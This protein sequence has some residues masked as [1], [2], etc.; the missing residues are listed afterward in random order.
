MKPEFKPYEQRKD[1]LSV[2]NGCILWGSRVVVPPPGRAPVIKMLHEGHPGVS[3]MK[4]LARSV[5]WWPGL[6]LELEKQVKQ[7]AECQ[8][9]QKSP[10]NAVLHPWE[11]PSKPWSRVHA[12]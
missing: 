12:Y 2:Q 4:A 10:P 8:E 11:W 9:A 1:E 6:D 5:V 3:R 7:C